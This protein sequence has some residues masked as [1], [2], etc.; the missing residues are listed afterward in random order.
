MSEAP[1]VDILDGGPS[2]T[3]FRDSSTAS[4]ATLVAASGRVGADS[5]GEIDFWDQ[6]TA[7][8]AVIT[9]ES[10]T[11]SGVLRFNNNS[12]AAN[13]HITNGGLM[14]FY[15]DSSAGNATI[16]L[17]GETAGITPFLRQCLRRNGSTA[18]AL[19][20][21]DLQ[22]HT[23]PGMTVGSVEGDGTIQLS[24]V[25]LRRSQQQSTTFSA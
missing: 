24:I 16:A 20:T 3:D 25:N 21:F 15:E 19:A 5:W 14:D 7:E 1:L 18:W 17:Q 2:E 4:N 9:V 8:N 22:L 23:A 11:N 6:S 13:A 12:T 10:G